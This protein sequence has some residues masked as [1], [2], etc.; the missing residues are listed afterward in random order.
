[1]LVR[2]SA[3]L[4][5]GLFRGALAALY[6]N[7]AGLVKLEYDFVI[8]LAG[9]AG[10]V[11]ANRLSAN[12]NVSV[13]L[14]EA[15]VNDTGISELQIPLLAAR[16]AFFDPSLLWNY[17]TTSQTALNGRVISYQRGR[18]LGGCSSIN[19]MYYTRGSRDDFNRFANVTGDSGWS[20]SSIF[21]YMLKV[22]N[23]TAPVDHHDTSGQFDPSLHGD[24]GPLL[25]TLPGFP[26][27]LDQRLLATTEEDS[28]RFPFNLDMNS[29]DTIG[30]GWVQSTSGNGVRSSSATAYLHPILDR[31]NLDLLVDTQATRVLQTGSRHGIP[32]L[33]GVELANGVSGPRVTVHARHEV[34]LSAG[35]VNTPQLLLLSGIGNRHDLAALGIPALVHSP[36]VGQ[37]LQDHPLL[38]SSWSVNANDTLDAGSRNATLY[39]ELLEQWDTSRTGPLVDTGGNLIAW[40]RLPSVFS[41]SEDPSAGPTSA[42]VELIPSNE[43][44]SFSGEP[45]PESGSYV[46]VVTGVISPASRGSV[47]LSSANPFD[48]PAIDPGLFTNDLDVA[49]MVEAIR[50]SY[51]LLATGP[52]K[53]LA[54]RPYGLLADATT[55]AGLAQYVRNSTT[56]FWHPTGTAKMGTATDDTAVLDSKLRVKGAE[57]LR[58]VDASVFPFIT[59][60]HPQAPIYAIAERAADLILSQLYEQ[61]GEH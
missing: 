49:V 28:G 13:L 53:D 30:I 32:I 29:G 54:A 23:F 6:N 40:L 37:N 26:S 24:R 25:P 18:L 48:P 59:A 12:H 33:R 7:T 61:V 43:W 44:N 36:G 39:G 46:S 22:E 2:Y 19:L 56:S 15:G 51:A 11:I 60:S 21:P 58:V 16:N 31:P 57:G 50:T 8:H 20:W 14:V 27:P 41:G 52:W 3:F 4:C 42:H 1:M 47:T 17:N 35:A 9:T 5:V 10:N 38:S 45:M 55:D 34:I